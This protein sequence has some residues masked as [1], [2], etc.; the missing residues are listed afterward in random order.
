[1]CD[2]GTL[3]FIFRIVA[4]V[5]VVVISG[6]IGRRTKRILSSDT[7][8]KARRRN[9]ASA[10][11][12]CN[13]RLSAHLDRD[14]R[15][16]SRGSSLLRWNRRSTISLDQ[17]RS[18]GGGHLPEVRS[19]RIYCREIF[20]CRVH[21]ISSRGVSGMIYLP[22][23]GEYPANRHTHPGITC[24]DLASVTIAFAARYS[25]SNRMLLLLYYSL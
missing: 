5:V 3:S 25:L 16:H 24:S 12:A 22:R 1:M 20:H 13:V 8:Q 7:H 18:S 15:V 9:T 17:S 23:P 6:G 11:C 19:S 21:L 14:M 10:K 4:V 2:S